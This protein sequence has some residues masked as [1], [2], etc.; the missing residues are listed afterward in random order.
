[1][2]V[3][4]VRDEVNSSDIYMYYGEISYKVYEKL[5]QVSYFLEMIKRSSKNLKDSKIIFNHPIELE[6]S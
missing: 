1:M 6:N 4:L 5:S 2:M 3:K